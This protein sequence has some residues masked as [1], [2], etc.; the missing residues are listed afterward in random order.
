MR[1]FSDANEWKLAPLAQPIGKILVTERELQRQAETEQ[2][3]FSQ[4]LRTPLSGFLEQAPERGS[5][6][7][8]N[9]VK[10]SCSREHTLT[11]QIK[12]SPA[13]HLPLDV[14]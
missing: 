14:L 3:F 6:A 1:G 4:R 2:G 12:I 9:S 13:I 8:S 5:P 10:S 7:I 11:Q